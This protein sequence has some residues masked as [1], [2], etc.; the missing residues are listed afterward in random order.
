V[1]TQDD[2]AGGPAHIDDVARRAGV[3]TATVSRSLR[4]LDRVAPGTR[5]RVARAAQ[6]LHYVPSPAASQL[7]SRRTHAIGVVVTSVGR[8]FWSEV[9]GA[10]EEVLRGAG[11]DL[12]LYLLD[13]ASARRQFFELMPLRRRVDAVLV[14]ASSVTP[15]EQDALREVEV[16]ILVVGGRMSGSDSV[17]VDDV[18]VAVTA[19]RH[20]VALGHRDVVMVCS[21]AADPS[22]R[23]TTRLRR[24]GF[25]RVL[26]EH[27]L[28]G[29]VVSTHPG[30][31]GG[32]AAVEELLGPGDLPTA[33][34]A[35]TDELALGALRAL[36]R[37]GISVPG[38]MSVVGIDDHELADAVDLTTVAR[39]P[40]AQGSTAAGQLLA[41]LGPR[42]T[43]PTD[44]VLPAGIVLRRTT[45]PP[46]PPA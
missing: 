23:R 20:L 6:E 42:P 1:T 25:E 17:R 2:R 28:T 7:A 12:L 10:A 13:Q 26:A 5:E 43:R 9:V 27:G 37:A 33:I 24:S 35:E 41:A 45:G 44:V 46:A 3:S 30:I 14:L 21:N 22:T 8:W 19:A 4:G 16:P 36:R 38:R 39:S 31:D 15:R 29:R 34:L 40:S 18:G 32:A 11:Y